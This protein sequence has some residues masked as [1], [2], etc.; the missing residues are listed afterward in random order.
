MSDLVKV[1]ASGDTFA[2]EL[3]R[4]R[5]EAEGIDVLMKGEGEGVYRAGPAY[6]F[7]SAE[8]EERARAVVEAVESGAFALGGG[9][10]ARADQAD[11]D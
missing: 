9:R 1:Y 4:G 10:G 7:V 3:M 6:L 2:A 11:G 5:L 8:D